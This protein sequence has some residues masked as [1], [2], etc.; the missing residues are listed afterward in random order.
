MLSLVIPVYR[1]EGS[2]EALVSAIESISVALENNFEAVFVVDG[3]PDNSELVLRQRLPQANFSSQLLSLSRNFG[4]FHAISAGLTA[5]KGDYFAVMAADLQEPPQLV[6]RFFKELTQDENS[7]DL[8]FG[9]RTERNDPFFSKVFSGIFWGLYRRFVISDVPP[10]GVDIFACNKRVKDEIVRLKERSSSLVGLLFWVGF[11]RSFIPYV[12]EERR[13]GKSAWTFKKRWNYLLDSFFSFTNLPIRLL[14]NIGI[15]GMALSILA[16]L[17][18]I[19]AKLFGGITVPG[20]T[21]TILSILFFGGLN[22]LGIGIV[23]EYVWRT[24]LNTQQRPNFI[25]REQV[26]FRGRSEKIKARAEN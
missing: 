8:V 26:N 10:G 2:I 19:F 4:A 23:G 14:M 3:S 13:H 7:P 20:Y 24:F 17:T 6:E 18:V 1:N 12:R 21:A 11:K 5:A 9:I 16:G 22:S 15:L 25:I